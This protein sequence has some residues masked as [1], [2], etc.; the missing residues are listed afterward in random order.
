MY[1]YLSKIEVPTIIQYIGSKHEYKSWHYQMLHRDN[2]CRVVIII[3]VRIIYKEQSLTGIPG[4]ANYWNNIH[5]IK[6]PDTLA[7]CFF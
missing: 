5:T 6:D 4:S 7:T 2:D 1:S 3:Y